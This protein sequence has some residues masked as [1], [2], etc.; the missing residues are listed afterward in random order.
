[1][2]QLYMV[3]ITDTFSGEAN[4]SWV[5]HHVISAKSERGAVNRLSRL[6]GINWRK[7]YAERYNS[8]SGA[9]CA[10]VNDYEPEYHENLRFDTD[11]RKG[12]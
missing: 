9:I 1:M 12:G 11:D 2:K 4:Y 5:T 10:F 7:D 3:E 6:S 8:V